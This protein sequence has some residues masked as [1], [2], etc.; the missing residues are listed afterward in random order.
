MSRKIKIT[1]KRRSRSCQCYEC[2]EMREIHHKILIKNRQFIEVWHNKTFN[3]IAK[4]MLQ[5]RLFLDLEIA[6]R[7]GANKDGKKSN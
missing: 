7:K 6:K 4:K 5:I 1:K 2:K 3:R